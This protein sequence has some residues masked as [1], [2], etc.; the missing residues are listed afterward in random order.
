MTN[1]TIVA[2][3]NVKQDKIDF[4]KNEMIKLIGKTLLEEGC[5]QYR[6]HQDNNNP[7]HFLFYECWESR[8]LWQTHRE[9]TH[10]VAYRAVVEGAIESFDVSE[11]TEL[12]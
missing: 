4:V 10:M 3:I 7:A 1:L 2:S 8:E 6:L 9:N 11:M 12:S 5:V